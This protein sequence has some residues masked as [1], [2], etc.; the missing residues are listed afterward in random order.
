MEFGFT[1]KPDHSIERTVALAKQAEAAGFAYGWLFDSHVLWRDPVP[2]PDADGTGHHEPPAGD[3]R[4]E[5]GHARAVGDRL[6]P[7]RP[8]GALRGSLRP[9][10][11]ARRLGPPGPR[12]G[13]DDDGHPR[14]GGPRH[15]GA[16]RGAPGR[17]RGRHAPAH[18][19]GRPSP[20]GLDRRVR[21]GGPEDDRPDRRRGDAPDR[22]PGPHPLVRPAR[23]TIRPA[24]RAA[25]RMPSRSW[26]R[27]P[28]TSATSRTRA[29]ASAGSRPSWA[30]TSSTSSTSTRAS[31]PR[32]SPTT[33]V[34][35]RA[36]TTCTTPRS[37][38]RTQR[39]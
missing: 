21:A 18:L 6:G 38:A 31:C 14:G 36:T 13:A 8:P 22:R 17:V 27:R 1:I 35:A 9:R 32:R 4:D 16:R 33:S 5:P 34:A 15:P 2:A 19:V 37:A 7:G 30:T 39:S 20:A 10:D 12:Q 25:T 29:T 24:R 28:P 3:L 26:R 23:S 11:R